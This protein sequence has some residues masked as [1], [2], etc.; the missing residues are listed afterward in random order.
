MGREVQGGGG[1]GMS[2]LR[3]PRGEQGKGVLRFFVA[4]KIS[5]FFATNTA[6]IVSHSFQKT[7]C[8]RTHVVYLRLS[9]LTSD[10]FQS[11]EKVRLGAPVILA[12]V[13]VGSIERL[14]LVRMCR[15]TAV[16]GTIITKPTFIQLAP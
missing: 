11:R 7:C 4:R 13:S 5:V 10:S 14:L 15:F 16:T 9:E 6:T 12:V 8:I 2:C 1:R 3:L